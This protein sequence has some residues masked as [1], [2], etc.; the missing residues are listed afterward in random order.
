MLRNGKRRFFP[1]GAKRVPPSAPVAARMC[2]AH[3]NAALLTWCPPPDVHRSPPSS[4]ILERRA[5]GDAEWVP[6]LTTDVAS[7][8]EVPGDGVPREADYHFRVCSA[9]QYGCSGHVEF[10]GSV[11][12][13]P[14]AHVQRGLQDVW[15]HVG[16]DAVF[17]VQLSAAVSGSWFLNGKRLEEEDQQCQI[18]Q[19]GVE[20]TMRINNVQLAAGESKVRFEA[21]GVKECA[22]L[23]V[24]G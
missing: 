18:T 14:R 20:H 12:L 16:E 21:G 15:V 23:N 4:Y 13:V 3:S 10:P 11:H 1:P 17:S 22:V 7:T 5:V 6:C 19:S 9:N 8:V 24:Q 2:V